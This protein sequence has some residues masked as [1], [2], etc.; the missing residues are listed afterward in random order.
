MRNHGPEVPDSIPTGINFFS[1][2]S[3]GSGFKFPSA[4]FFGNFFW[5]FSKIISKISGIILQLP[6]IF[7]EIFQ[8]NFQ[9]FSKLNYSIPKILRNNFWKFTNYFSKFSDFFQ[10]ISWNFPGYFL[11]ISGII[12]DTFQNTSRN[13]RKNF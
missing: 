1:N 6:E 12:F 11:R 7:I 2:F 5:N 3:R 10:N 9:S 8:N 4:K 13:F